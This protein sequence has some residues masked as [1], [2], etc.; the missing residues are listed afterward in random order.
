M[1]SAEEYILRQSEPFKAIL[2]QI[3]LVVEQTIPEAVLLYKYRIPFYY[4]QGKRPFCYLNCSRGYVDLG[5]WNGS[6]L[7]VHTELMITE[8]RK[9]IKSLR[10]FTAEDIN[11]DVLKAVLQNAYDVRDKKF[12]N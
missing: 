5:F 7:T 2:L 4:L 10:Y 12:Y 8:G 1:N 11:H 9:Q 3:Q 6:H